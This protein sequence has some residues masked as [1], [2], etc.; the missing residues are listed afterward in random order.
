M[1]I[2]DSGEQHGNE[3]QA[4]AKK[5]RGEKTIFEQANVVAHYGHEPQESEPCKWNQVQ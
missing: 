4:T 2:G 1:G 5:H 3:Q